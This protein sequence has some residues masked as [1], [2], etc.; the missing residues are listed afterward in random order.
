MSHAKKLKKYV[1]RERQP[2]LAVATESR[3]VER[4]EAPAVKGPPLKLKNSELLNKFEKK[5]SHLSVS[6]RE[7]LEKLIKRYPGLFSV[8]I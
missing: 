7:D 2:V 3:R 5:V 4:K 6:E 1:R 8:E